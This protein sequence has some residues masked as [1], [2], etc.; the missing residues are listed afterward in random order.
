MSNE[1]VV[2]AVGLYGGGVAASG[3]T[4]G[5]VFGAAAPHGGIRC[6][7][8]ARVD[9]RDPAAVKEYYSNPDSRFGVCAQ[10]VGDI[11]A[12]LGEIIDKEVTPAPS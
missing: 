6:R 3:Y 5:A 2:K 10:L 4:C 9:W 11:A 8:I 1:A 12:A 7:D